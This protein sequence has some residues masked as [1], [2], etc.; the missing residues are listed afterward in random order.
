[1]ALSSLEVGRLGPSFSLAAA[2]GGTGGGAITGTRRGPDEVPDCV[3]VVRVALD[4]TCSLCEPPT[5]EEVVTIVPRV[6]PL[7]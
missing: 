2:E 7:V 1:M 4:F 3:F 6:G 5:L